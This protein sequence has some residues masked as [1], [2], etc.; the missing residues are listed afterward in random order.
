MF[1]EELK[2]NVLLGGKV[3]H[4]VQFWE[5]LTKD[6]EISEIMKGYKILLLRSVTS[7]EK[8]FSGYTPK[9]IRNF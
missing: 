7:P 6:Q 2:Q 8:K 5:K 1:P 3:S 9:K 4:F